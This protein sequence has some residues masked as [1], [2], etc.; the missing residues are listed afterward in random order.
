MPLPGKCCKARYAILFVAPGNAG[1]AGIATNL[2]IN[3]VDFE[4]V[5]TAVL[6]NNVQLVVGR[7]RRPAG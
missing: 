3:P 6:T 1:T 2:A 7:P 4:A 5:K